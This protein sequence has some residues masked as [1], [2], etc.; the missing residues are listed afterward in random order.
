MY[1]MYIYIYYIKYKTIPA[2]S[3]HFVVCAGGKRCRLL[4]RWT[5]GRVEEFGLK[6]GEFDEFA[7]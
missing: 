6:H 3:V 4:A 5:E 1:I 7:H 2:W